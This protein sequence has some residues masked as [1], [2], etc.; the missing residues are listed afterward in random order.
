[1]QERCDAV[2]RKG[3]GALMGTLKE[4]TSMLSIVPENLQESA[5]TYCVC[6]VFT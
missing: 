5:A 2:L 1:M 4:E 6:S 3:P